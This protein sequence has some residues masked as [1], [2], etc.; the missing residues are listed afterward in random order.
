VHPAWRALANTLA[1]REDRCDQAGP[2]HWPGQ[3]IGEVI[4]VRPKGVLQVSS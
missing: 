3:E 4:G 1:Q 2:P